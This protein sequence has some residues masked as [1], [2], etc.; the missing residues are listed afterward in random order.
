MTLILV[1][2]QNDF[3]PGGALAVPH[4]DQIVPIVNKMVKYA[5]SADKMVVA[6]KDWHPAGHGSFAST[7]GAEV[8][9]MGKLDGLDQVMWPDHCIQETNGSEFHPDLED[10]DL[11]SAVICKGLD[12]KVDSYSGFFDNAKRN[13]TGLHDFL[14]EREAHDLYICGL[15]RDYCVGFTCLD[16]AELGYNVTLIYDATKAVNYPEGNDESM[17]KKMLDAGIN[18]ITSKEFIGE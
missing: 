13:S 15:A 5:F 3:M 1:D 2:I 14:K 16:A 4:G 11:F 18:I 8:M 12:P 10:T 6:T 9:T 17:I 7:H